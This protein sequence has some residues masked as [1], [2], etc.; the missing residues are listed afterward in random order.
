MNRVLNTDELLR[1]L[2]LVARG[3]GFVF[4]VYF[5]PALLRDLIGMGLPGGGFMGAL[6]GDPAGPWWPLVVTAATMAL[7]IAGVRFHARVERDPSPARANGR[8]GFREWGLG[9][10]AGTGV[11][12][13]AMIPAVVSGAFEF[14]GPREGGAPGA[15]VF[16]AM[17]LMLASEAAREELGFRG[18]AQRDLARAITTPAAAIFLAG[19]FALIHRA[20]PQMTTAGLVGVF[21]AGFALAGLARARGGVAMVC[22]FHAGWNIAL[23]LLWCAPVSGFRLAAAPLETASNDSWLSGGSFGPE[24]SA[25]GIVVLAL[26]GIVAWTRTPAET[27][28]G[29]A[30]SDAQG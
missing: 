17:L 13:L 16:A 2:M 22:G 19:S 24:G 21:L 1:R 28:R 12:S 25:P 18:P 7:S 10:L 20:N 9:F 6:E 23:G 5:I 30:R 3:L 15:G 26:L 27:W 14:V 8:R 11:A 29:A 4:L